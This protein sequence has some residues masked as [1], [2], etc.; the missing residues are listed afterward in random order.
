M[1]NYNLNSVLNLVLIFRI[2]WLKL[3][4]EKN[5]LRE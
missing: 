3:V 5:Q 2:L 1:I 4:T